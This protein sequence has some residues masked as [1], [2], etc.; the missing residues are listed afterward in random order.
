MIDELSA[1][2]DALLPLRIDWVEYQ[3]PILT[4]GGE[5]WA[6]AL[7]CP[8]RLMEGP[9]AVT[10]WD[11][12]GVED[13]SWNLVGHLITAVRPRLDGNSEDP[14]F[15]ISGAL[16]LE[17]LADTDLDPWVLRLDLTGKTFV[18]RS[19]LGSGP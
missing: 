19:G 16:V 11:E 6:L 14:A 8:W 4:L 2:L 3:D 17:V 13:E 18:G 5:R 7:A 1:A 12:P 15:S 9:T 10:A